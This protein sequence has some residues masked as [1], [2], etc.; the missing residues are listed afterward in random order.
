M[1]FNS[2]LKIFKMKKKNIRIFHRAKSKMKLGM[3][4]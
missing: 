3:P 4:V 2:D 1:F